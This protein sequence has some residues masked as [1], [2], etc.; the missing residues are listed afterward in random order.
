MVVGAAE[1]IMAERIAAK[2]IAGDQI[3]YGFRI[4]K[5]CK[6]YTLKEFIVEHDL[7]NIIPV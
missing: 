2:I 1:F 5:V 4:L 3:Q 7:H 6:V